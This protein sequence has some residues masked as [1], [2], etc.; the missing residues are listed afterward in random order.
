MNRLA[1]YIRLSVE[2]G[3]NID[4]SESIVNQRLLLRDYVGSKSEFKPYDI[5]EYIDDGYSGTNEKR[6]AFQKML[7]DVKAGLVKVIIVKDLS[8]FMRDYIAIGDYLE[9]IFPFL[10][11]RFISIN[12]GYDSL[13]EKGNGT[14]LDIQF[15]SLLYDFYSKDASEKV[16]T[17]MTALRKQG[18]HIAWSP[19]Y[20]YMR[21]PAD[22]HK[23]VVDEKTAWVVKKI[24]SLALEGLSTRK[25]ATILNEEKIDMPNVRKK[26]LTNMDYGY[27]ITKSD[28]RKKPTW[29]NG[30]IID[31]LRN[32]NYTGTYVFN[33][34]DR[35]I[36][37]GGKTTYRPK[38]E[39]QRVYNN[40]EAIISKE[41]FD[42]VQEIK[43]KNRFLKGKNTDYKWYTKSPLQGFARCD[44]CNH[45][46][47]CSK[48]THRT[49]TMGVRYHIYFFCRTCKC[50][51]E[52]SNNSRAGDLEEQVFAEVKAR[53]DT[54]EEKAE[55]KVNTKN[56]GKNIEKL[57]TKKM[58]SFE[59]YKLGKISREKFRDIKSKIDEDI[60]RLEEEIKL[61]KIVPDKKLDDTLTRDMMEKYVDSVICHR[62]K[63]IK[64]IWK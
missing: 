27:M 59:K 20:G 34:Q 39:W 26:E 40:H 42:K 16:K 22:R 21:N 48:T 56:L 12:D 55:P 24:Y 9:N 64:I 15:K 3:L 11:V 30:A 47:A 14:E 23:I 2:D 54:R 41:D 33:T 31:I 50:N 35:S 25:I 57:K 52:N 5:E 44:K 8:R 1:L 32:E 63:V 51:G 28:N 6:P 36:A 17:V 43:E 61:A 46:L 18:K 60:A 53:F 62:S 45:I 4:E 58:N 37:N 19:P 13:N 7:E 49:K 10:G 29:S 38:E